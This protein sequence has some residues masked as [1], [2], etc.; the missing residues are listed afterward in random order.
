MIGAVI[1]F[2]LITWFFTPAGFQMLWLQIPI[3]AAYG[4]VVSFLRPTGI[5]AVALTLLA[6]LAVQAV[7]GHLAIGFG[8]MM[9]MIIYGVVGQ[10][11][12]IGERSKVIDGR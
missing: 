7:T 5:T 3:A 8:L 10:V 12:G 2:P 4:A 11:V 9:S 6:G 1:F